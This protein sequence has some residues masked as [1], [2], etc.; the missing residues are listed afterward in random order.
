MARSA[1]HP[2]P[3]E[4]CADAPSLA[5][6]RGSARRCPRVT[7]AC[8]PTP[9]ASLLRKKFSWGIQMTVFAMILGAFVAA[10]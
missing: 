10:R 2:M 7:A 4:P 1:E 6:H 3:G 5:P 8:V 9:L